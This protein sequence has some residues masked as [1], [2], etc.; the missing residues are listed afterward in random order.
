MKIPASP[1]AS[2][3]NRLRD[4]MLVGNPVNF[5]LQVL[6]RKADPLQDSLNILDHLR[7]PAKI[8]GCVGAVQTPLIGVFAN[9]VVDP[10]FFAGPSVVVPRTAYRGHIFEPVPFASV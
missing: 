5:F 7:M 9:Q 8:A 10:A 4:N 6:S 1:K 2:D 3:S